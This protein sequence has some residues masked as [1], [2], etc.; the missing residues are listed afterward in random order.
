LY[1]TSAAGRLRFAV[2]VVV[3]L[4]AWAS[5][6][7]LIEG[8]DRAFLLYDTLA[9]VAMMT[10]FLALGDARRSKRLLREETRRRL[11]LAEQDRQREAE[12]LVA[13]ERLSIARDLHDSMSH[14]ISV[15]ALHSQVAQESAPG[16]PEPTRAA[17]GR[18]RTA[19]QHAMRDLRGTVTSL[20]DDGAAPQP[21]PGLGQLPTLL[22]RVEAAGLR[23]ELRTTGEPYLL[24]P[25]VDT[26]AYR[27]VQEAL[28]NCLRHAGIEHAEL[29]LTYG[30]AAVEIAV[31]D[32]HPAAE[33]G[34]AAE[35]NGMRGM[36]ERV[37]LIGGTL[38]AGPG[39][40]GFGVQAHLPLV[41]A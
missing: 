16:L 3:V 8:D 34:T 35:G 26:T 5:T 40:D 20:R 28:T 33:P 30:P 12:Q 11:R 37:E 23:V 39:A 29:Q 36:R 10:A 15:I 1:V 6:I 9:T 2:G 25:I 27:V 38:T 32:R 31:V 41:A 21:L 7:R 22:D 17:L 13:A 18:I 14:D 4:L 19:A 24:P